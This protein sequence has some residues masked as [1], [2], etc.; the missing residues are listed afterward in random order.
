M[1]SEM[2][3]RPQNSQEEIDAGVNATGYQWVGSARDIMVLRDESREGVDV[4]F[5]EVGGAY[6][7]RS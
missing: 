5:R 3:A 6:C 2:L 7:S 4:R 1:R